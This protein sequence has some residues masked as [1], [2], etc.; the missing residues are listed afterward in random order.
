MRAKHLEVASPVVLLTNDDGFGAA[1]ITAM[2]AALE[3][4]GARV[5]TIAPE[6]NHTAGSH[7]VTVDG[8]LTITP[9]GTE[10][11][12]TCSGSP[13]DCVRAG[14]LSGVVPRPDLVVSGINHGANAGEDVH[15]SGTVAAA[16]EAALLGVPALA[17]S[18]HGDGPELP[19][20]T[21][22]PTGFPDADYAAQVALW[23]AGHGPPAHTFINLNLPCAPMRSPAALATLGRRDWQAASM[24]WEVTE[25][26]EYRLDP[27]AGA[28]PPIAD[29]GTDFAFL[30]DGVP[31]VSLLSVRGGL[32]DVLAQH[33]AWAE[34]VPRMATHPTS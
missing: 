3:Q 26:N 8:H 30:R 29:H 28:P 14:V 17:V 4:H 33:R 18:Q 24:R 23:V 12:F 7:R 9:V 25:A 21:R 34:S 19:F 11:T 31:T 6:A 16:V 13:A 1:G 20:L 22:T 2:H 5:V 15:Y 27:W 32:Y 10:L